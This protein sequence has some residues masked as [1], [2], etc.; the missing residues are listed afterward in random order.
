MVLMVRSYAPSA[1]FVHD[2]SVAVSQTDKA[3][4]FRRLCRDGAHTV[5]IMV[6]NDD[7]NCSDAFTL[8]IEYPKAPPDRF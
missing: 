4:P 6:F 3:R 8:F 5:S 1:E 2:E 7:T